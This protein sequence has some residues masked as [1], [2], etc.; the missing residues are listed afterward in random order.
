VEIG[1]SS[2]FGQLVVN[3]SASLD[4]TLTVTLVNGYQP[5]SGTT[6]RIL[7]ANPPI[8]G[9]FATLDGDGPLFT[10][11]YNPGDVTLTAN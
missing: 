2:S 5:T 9:S 7:K 10:P 1:S 4:G 8:S 3:G 11:T 6:F